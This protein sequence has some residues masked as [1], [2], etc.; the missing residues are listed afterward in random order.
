MDH[1]KSPH[2]CTNHW[3]CPICPVPR[4]FEIE[5]EFES[6]LQ[7]IHQDAVPTDAF[8][9][10]ALAGARSILS[11]AQRCP[12]CPFDVHDVMLDHIAKHVHSFSL[13]SLPWDLFDAEIEANRDS[14]INSPSNQ[15]NR[16]SNREPLSSDE[17]Y[18]ALH[19]ARVE[20]PSREHHFFIP[21][22]AKDSIITKDVIAK[23]LRA[24]YPSHDSKTIDEKAEEAHSKA[25]TIFAILA[26]IKKAGQILEF[27]DEQVF[28]KDLPLERG[29]NSGKCPFSLKRRNGGGTV[30]VLE[31]WESSNDREAFSRDQWLMLAPVFK[32]MKH[33]V[34]HQNHVLPFIA[35]EPGNPLKDWKTMAGYSEVFTARIH[36]AHH[37]FCQEWSQKVSVNHD[38]LISFTNKYIL[39][40]N[41]GGC[42]QEAPHEGPQTFRKRTKHLP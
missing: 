9:A 1:M 15:V 7:E 2:E 36:K 41:S 32:D 23:E 16:T 25:K 17:L 35:P 11:R 8:P 14:S 40:W 22:S 31:R 27:L 3:M 28:D 18:K 21:E 39:G 34:L 19:A 5:A 30:Q 10:L 20:D 26:Y 4:T 29:V 37:R 42:S 12:L 24:T 38:Y 6:H 13:R 33:Y